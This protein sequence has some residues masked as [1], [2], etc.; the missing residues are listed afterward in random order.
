MLGPIRGEAV[1]GRGGAEAP[2]TGRPSPDT[3][4]EATAARPLSPQPRAHRPPA[5]PPAGPEEAACPAPSRRPRPP[6]ALRSAPRP[7]FN[8]PPRPATCRP[9]RASPAS[10][11]AHQR[12]APPRRAPLPGESRPRPRAFPRPVAAAAPPPPRQ[13]P[14]YPGENAGESGFP[15]RSNRRP[16]ARRVRFRLRPG[17]PFLAPLPRGAR[18]P[19]SRGCEAPPA[20]ARCG[21]RAEAGAGSRR[22]RRRWT[23]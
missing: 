2:G 14:P 1:R 12:Q 20:R 17:G 19:W 15:F 7:S 3:R 21:S 16:P 10:R 4:C 6:A 5:A 23:N 18:G 13:A 22:S 8:P 11:P 9:F